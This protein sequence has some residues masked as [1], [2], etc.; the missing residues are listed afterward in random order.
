[1]RPA[2][3]HRRRK[4]HHVE[5][6]RHAGV[7]VARRATPQSPER[8]ADRV[9][10]RVA[11]IERA[12][13]IL[14]DHLEP[15]PERA[16]ARVDAQVA[17]LH[18][19]ERHAAGRRHL[20]AAHHLGQRRLPAAR[21]PDDRERLTP[22]GRQAHV[23]KRAHGRP[24]AAEPP[25]PPPR[26]VDLREIVHGHDGLGHARPIVHDCPA[27]PASPLRQF[28]GAHA[29][30][31]VSRVAVD[32]RHRD[33][34]GGTARGL[35]V[36]TT[37]GEAAAERPRDRGL[38]LAGDRHEGRLALVPAEGGQTLE[39]AARVGMAR[40][41][42]DLADG[43]LLDDAAAI[44]H[45]DAVAHAHDAAE[46]V[47][48][49]QDGRAMPSAQLAHQVEHGR[50]DG[51]VEP[52]RR[53]VGHQQLGREHEGH[54]DD[55]AL[56]HPAREL[57][58]IAVEPA[59]IEPHADEQRLGLLAHAVARAAVRLPDLVELVA[60]ARHRIERV[61][62]ALRNIGHV[63]PA[64]GAQLLGIEPDE[65]AAAQPH[66]AVGHR[67]GGRQQAE[68]AHGERALAAARFADDAERLAGLELDRDISHGAHGPAPAS[69]LDGEVLD[70]EQIHRRQPR[71]SRGFTTRS[72][73]RPIRNT[74]A[75]KTVM[76]RPGGTTD[77]HAWRIEPL[78]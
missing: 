5:Q 37:P 75:V 20:D 10:D 73:S 33:R 35:D 51:N 72:Y 24:R 71:S 27:R 74:D 21:L 77:H 19:L 30:H 58:R 70:A 56:P 3:R 9:A 69:V 59:R 68:H 55:G 32:R 42:E 52:G 13:G 53:L 45:P 2:R 18:A 15:A 54:R 11:R 17:D 43:A 6:P 48:D 78:M 63:P 8:A 4:L 64:Q 36:C 22:L 50:L 60:Q 14:E 66:G 41:G 16:A 49:E 46:I 25:T 38:H 28:A 1:M 47:A 44:H 76:Q 23:V 67:G 12:V 34:R 65:I 7:D 40:I 31:V 57:V 26:L 39:E 62:R 29:G 61:H